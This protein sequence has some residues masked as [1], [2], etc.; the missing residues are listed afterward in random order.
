M[1]REKEH[2]DGKE[3]V[4]P[5][6]PGRTARPINA[7]P[8]VKHEYDRQRADQTYAEPENERYGE[9]EFGEENDGIEDVEIEKIDRGD[10]LAMEFER[11]ALA[12]LLGPVFQAARHG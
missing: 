4:G 2:H 5:W 1:E 10:Q 12:H 6:P 11:G 9:C 7:E 8:E 3:N